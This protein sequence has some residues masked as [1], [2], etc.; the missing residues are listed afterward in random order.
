MHRLLRKLEGGDR[1]SIGRAAE[2]VADVSRDPRLF[3]V[4]LDGL[5]VDDPVVRMRAADALEKVSRE[6]PELLAPFRDRLLALAAATGQNEVR[7]H[8]AQVLPRLELDRAARRAVV[9]TLSGYLSDGSR[10]VATCVMQA[11]ADIAEVDEVLRPALLRRVEQLAAS[12]SPAM[13]ARGRK[14]LA[15]FGRG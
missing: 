6:Q 2:V 14:L 15:C 13:R 11:F 4:L 7:W 10:I 5:D 3:A 9:E 8:L 1:R 12:G